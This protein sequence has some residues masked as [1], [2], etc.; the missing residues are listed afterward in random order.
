MN[1]IDCIRYLID[2]PEDVQNVCFAMF[3]FGFF[4]CLFMEFVM[5]IFRIFERLYDR[6]LDKKF[7]VDKEDEK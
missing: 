1:F 3:A 6:W 4:A 2:M 5:A 7:P